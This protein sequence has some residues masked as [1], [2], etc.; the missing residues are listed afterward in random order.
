MQDIISA[1]GAFSNYGHERGEYLSPI[2]CF[3]FFSDQCQKIKAE[4]SHKGE[5]ILLYI[6]STS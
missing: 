4:S 1:K 2:V 5:H 6:T 3:V